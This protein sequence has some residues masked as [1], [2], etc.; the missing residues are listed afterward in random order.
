MIKGM[1]SSAASAAAHINRAF[2]RNASMV[3]TLAFSAVSTQALVKEMLK[4]SMGLH[5]SRCC[6][7]NRLAKV[8]FGSMSTA[9]SG[10]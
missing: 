9:S 5:L 2:A 4:S 8:T 10:V 7:M 1:L 6:S 3:S